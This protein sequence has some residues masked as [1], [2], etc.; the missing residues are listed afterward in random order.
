[1][2]TNN[3]EYSDGVNN[4]HYL[5]VRN[6]SRL[7][8][9]TTS[10]HNGDFYCSNCFHSYTTKTRLEKHE[11]IC[12]DY[13]FCNIKMPNEDNKNI[14]IQLRRKIIKISVYYLC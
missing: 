8:R 4:W 13:D 6:L 10:N 7:L 5:V 3:D 9:G 11:K 14:R 12:K 2:I 1:M